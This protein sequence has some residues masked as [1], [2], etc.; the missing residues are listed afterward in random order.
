MK[1]TESQCA[2]SHLLESS[3]IPTPCSILVAPTVVPSNDSFNH[4]E[5]EIEQ[6]LFL[7]LVFECP[8]LVP[9]L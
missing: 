7:P 3:H 6:C 9:R 8:V 4:V 5:S 1:V 2:I